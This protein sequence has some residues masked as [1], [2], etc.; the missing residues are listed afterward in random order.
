MNVKLSIIIP[1]H[2]NPLKLERLLSS[3]P[4]LNY[5]E[6]II[7]NDHGERPK[8]IESFCKLLNIKCFEQVPGKKW[9][10][11]ARNLGL[12]KAKGEFV[13]FADSDDYFINDSFVFLFQYLDY[14]FDLVFFRPVSIKET[15]G[16][17][18][19]HIR[20]SSLIDEYLLKN[21]RSILYKFHPPWSKLYKRSFLLE[22]NICFDEVIASNDVNFSLKASYFAR[23]NFIV[24]E[25]SF[26]C[27]TESALSLT[28]TKNF[29]VASSRFLA[30]CH[31][32]D[33]LISKN[34]KNLL[35]MI[36]RLLPFLIYSP[37]LFLD[38]ILLC[39][40]KGYPLFYSIFDVIRIFKFFVKK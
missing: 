16:E 10:G 8:I 22:E 7:V 24:D 36:N 6:V 1:Y 2:S 14:S 19:R 5:L 15:G 20:Y 32:N 34:E 39:R 38:N 3:I 31:Y 17:S 28:K 9:A 21:D 11:A 25:K 26:Y 29:E 40:S 27:V 13:I 37:V 35:P 23:N 18:T 33:F 30:L 12:K 4:Q